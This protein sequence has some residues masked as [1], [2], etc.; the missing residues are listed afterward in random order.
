MRAVYRWWA[1]IILLGI[2]VQV[3]FAGYGAFYVAHKVDKGV[4]NESKFEDGFGLHAGFG[5][6]VV[7]GALVLL[8]LALAARVGKRRILQTLGLFGLFIV[9]VLL[10]WIGFGVP[11]VGAL[12]PINA[13]AIFAFAGY[14]VSTEWRMKKAAAPVAEPP[15]TGL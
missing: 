3:G 10:A 4:V 6:L 15:A 14:L 7:L 13:L 1:T 12:H 11:A 5:Y 9:Q 2:V 8:L